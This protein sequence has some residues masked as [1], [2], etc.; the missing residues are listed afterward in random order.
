MTVV[1]AFQRFFCE[2][3]S[4]KEQTT[5]ACGM[6]EDRGWNIWERSCCVRFPPAE[7][8]P[9]IIFSGSKY[10]YCDDVVEAV[11]RF[12]QSTGKDGIE[13]EI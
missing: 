5:K 10:A 7:P 2:E 4:D 12:A 3:R 13:K 8:P 6:G 1:R 9:R 11:R